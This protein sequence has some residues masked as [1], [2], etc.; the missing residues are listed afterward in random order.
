MLGNTV[1][2]LGLSK[3]RL[4]DYCLMIGKLLS[5]L[6]LLSCYSGFHL[7]LVRWLT[8]GSYIQNAIQTMLPRRYSEDLLGHT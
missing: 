2:N 4:L 3:D 1:G 7:V 8:C 6:L 5:L